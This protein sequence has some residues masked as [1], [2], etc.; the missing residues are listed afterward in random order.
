MDKQAK[1]DAVKPMT[2]PTVETGILVSAL[3]MGGIL[4]VFYPLSASA[5]ED[6]IVVSTEVTV[7]APLPA[8]TVAEAVVVV[9][10]TRAE[11]FAKM[12]EEAPTGEVIVITA[13]DKPFTCDISITGEN[14]WSFDRLLDIAMRYGCTVTMDR[15]PTAS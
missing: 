5:E 12:F 10:E 11:K 1:E 7:E 3:V 9:E 2:W 13:S 8:L 14:G 6:V 15:T 4:S